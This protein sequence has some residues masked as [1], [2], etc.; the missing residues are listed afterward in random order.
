MSTALAARAR[1][2]ADG[3]R[4]GALDAKPVETLGRL[5]M[6][7]TRACRFFYVQHEGVLLRGGRG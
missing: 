7:S 2:S 4:V 6:R 5:F 3:R 1:R